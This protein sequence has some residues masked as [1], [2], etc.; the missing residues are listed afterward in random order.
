MMGISQQ[1]LILKCWDS[2]H[3]YNI[4]VNIKSVQRSTENGAEEFKK[5]QILQWTTDVYNLE[6]AI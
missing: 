4:V 6:M 5:E 1:C 2:Y 3:E